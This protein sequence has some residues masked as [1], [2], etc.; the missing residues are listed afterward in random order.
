MGSGP[1]PRP[2]RWGRLRILLEPMHCNAWCLW[3]FHRSSQFASSI[4]DFV[5]S[6]APAMLSLM[7]ILRGALRLGRC[8]H[9]GD[10]QPPSTMPLSAAN[11]RL[12]G[13][14]AIN[15]CRPLHRDR[16]SALAWQEH[17]RYSMLL[18]RFVDSL[19]GHAYLPV[20]TLHPRMRPLGH[21]G[22][23]GNQLA[24]DLSIGYA[25]NRSKCTST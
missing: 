14:D 24:N 23:V 4:A 25:D 11:T 16:T 9:C 13:V 10:P 3:C 8:P 18:E 22:I 15:Q 19:D 2:R 17:I 1:T 5:F 7:W 21:H 12:P 6:T 20:E